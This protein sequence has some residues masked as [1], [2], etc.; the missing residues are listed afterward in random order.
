MRIG[1]SRKSVFT[2]AAILLAGCGGGGNSTTGP[3]VTGTPSTPSTPTGTSNAVAVQNN[4]FAPA[5]L[6]T[7]AGATVTWTWNTCSGGDGYGSGDVCVAH[8]I[9]FDDGPTSGSQSSGTYERTFAT[10]GT[11]PYHCLIHGLSMSGTVVVQ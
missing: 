9:K 10:K 3:N 2:I 5:S 11:Y 4:S 6:T 1:M 8:N 7:S